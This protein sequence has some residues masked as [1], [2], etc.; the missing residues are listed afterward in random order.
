MAARPATATRCG[1]LKLYRQVPYAVGHAF[2][3]MLGQ[4]AG[5]RGVT[6]AARPA[7]VRLVHVNIMQVQ[8]AVSKV[9]QVGRLARQHNA[10]RVTAKTECVIL[11]AERG[12]KLRGILL[13]QQ[14]VVVASMCN[15]T[16]A[17]IVLCDGAVQ[18]F[19]VFD[20]I[21]ESRNNFVFADSHGFIVARHAKTCGVL[22]QQKFNG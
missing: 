19:L 10:L 20:L 18:I 2:A 17:A 12:V 14:T 4:V 16:A 9:R 21:R 11:F 7:S 5:V 3:N 8:V 1:F 22:F 6:G 15:V 13:R